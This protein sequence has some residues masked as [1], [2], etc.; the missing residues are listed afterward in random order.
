MF[1]TQIGRPP[2]SQARRCL[3]F[4]HL[5]DLTKPCDV[6]NDWID[7]CEAENRGEAYGD[8]QYEEEIQDY[9]AYDQQEEEEEE[10]EEDDDL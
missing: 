8:D 1:V 10:E 7:S 2:T 6:F 5:T 9:G 4:I 3:S